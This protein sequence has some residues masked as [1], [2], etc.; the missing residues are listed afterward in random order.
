M[1][2]G[3][4]KVE[5]KTTNSNCD[6]KRASDGTEIQWNEAR[7]TVRRGHEGA[8]ELRHSKVQALSVALRPTGGIFPLHQPPTITRKTGIR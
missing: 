2:I 3:G 5:G 4:S 6:S 1:Y 7:N 8:G